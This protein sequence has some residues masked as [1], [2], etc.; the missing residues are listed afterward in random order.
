MDL[1]I[2]LRLP[3]I[4]NPLIP[5]VFGPIYL[6]LVALNRQGGHQACGLA[7]AVPLKERNVSSAVSRCMFQCLNPIDDRAGVATRDD[8]SRI[9]LEITHRSYPA[10]PPPLRT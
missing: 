5:T 10:P 2:P 8:K 9:E 6:S 4:F 1:S 7:S 3:L